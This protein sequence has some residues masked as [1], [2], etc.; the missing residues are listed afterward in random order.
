MGSLFLEVVAYKAEISTTRDCKP[1][2]CLIVLLW[3]SFTPES[4]IIDPGAD[5]ALL[6]VCNPIA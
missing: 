5:R 3:A 2:S 6:S 4:D 1:Q